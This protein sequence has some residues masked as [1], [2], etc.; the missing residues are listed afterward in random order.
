MQTPISRFL[1]EDLEEDAHKLADNIQLMMGGLKIKLHA[2]WAAASR[3]CRRRW[4]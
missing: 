3:A 4:W 2:V 1:L